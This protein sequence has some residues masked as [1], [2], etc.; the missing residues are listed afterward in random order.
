[1][2][3]STKGRYAARAMLALAAR[4]KTGP[5]RAG[6]IAEDQGISI[7]YLENILAA[8]KSAGLIIAVRGS[9]GGYTLARRPSSITLYDVLL[10]LEDLSGIAPRGDK[11]GKNV[12]FEQ[13]VTQDVWVELQNAS[14]S[15]LKRKTLNS[16]LK[17]KR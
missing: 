5:M 17:G 14:K 11:R 2:F 8:L 4:Y 9:Q 12:C 13:S 10:P 1:M 6:E 15:I 16:L 3:I 7:K